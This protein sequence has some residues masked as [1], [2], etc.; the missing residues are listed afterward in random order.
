M[1]VYRI[2]SNEYIHDLSGYGAKL[3]GSRWNR[4]GVAVLYTGSSIALC[5]WEYW[6]HLPPAITLL[7]NAFSVATIEI[8]DTSILTIKATDLPTDWET[9]E[10]VLFPITDAWIEENKHLVMQVPSAIIQ[11]EWNYLINPL[12]ALFTKVLLKSVAP[13]AFDKRAFGKALLKNQ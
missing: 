12:H 7:Q 11:N 6:V 8:P 5:A 2:A 1:Q 10:G 4:E 3:N 13:F 9:D